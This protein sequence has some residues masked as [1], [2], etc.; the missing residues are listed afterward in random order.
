MKLRLSAPPRE[1]SPN[2]RSSLH[3][4]KRSALVKG[5]RRMVSIEA[6]HSARGGA[7]PRWESARVSVTI[8]HRQE[9]HFL[10]P[11]DALGWM[12]TVFDGLTDAG[13][14]ADDRRLTHLPVLQVVDRERFGQLDV[15][16]DPSLP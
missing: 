9:S 5:H 11:G 13:V 8:Y 10:D 14:F 2:R 12:K 6:R 4:M 15:E 1:L 7:K 3:H 16:I